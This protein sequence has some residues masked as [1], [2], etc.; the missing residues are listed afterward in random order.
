MPLWLSF[1]SASASAAYVNIHIFLWKSTTILIL[2]RLERRMPWLQ[3]LLNLHLLKLENKSLGKEDFSAN[4]VNWFRPMR[5][6]K[7]NTTSR[8]SARLRLSL[9]RFQ[10]NRM[11][12]QNFQTRPF[13]FD[14]QPTNLGFRKEDGAWAINKKAAA[15][16]TTKTKW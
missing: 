15:A 8:F 9:R 10:T 12:S 6:E 13:P 14:S 4:W 2:S 1:S 7:K 5:R 16:A 11:D 3:Y